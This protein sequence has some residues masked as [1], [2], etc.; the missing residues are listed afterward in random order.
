M[1][2]ENLK[3]TDDRAHKVAKFKVTDD[4][5]LQGWKNFK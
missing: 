5:A 4:E 3:V 2:A 1:G